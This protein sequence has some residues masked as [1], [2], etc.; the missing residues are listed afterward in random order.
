MGHLS[1]AG[2]KPR[3]TVETVGATVEK[4]TEVISI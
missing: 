1:A 3:D 4:A 2:V